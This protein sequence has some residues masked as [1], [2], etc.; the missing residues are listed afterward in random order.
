MVVR[1][2]PLSTALERL[3]SETRI[4]LAY[5]PPLV[6]G[7][8]TSCVAEKVTAEA[9][10]RCVLKG[11]DVD[12]YQLSSG[13]YVLIETP[14]TVPLYGG[15]RGI[16]VDAE[17]RQ[18]LPRSHVML[19]DRESG[20][21]ANEAG[22]FTFSRLRP[23]RYIV[24]ATHVGYEAAATTV[25]V[26]PGGDTQAELALTSD[27][28]LVQ[29]IVIDGL[30]WRLPSA[31]LGR[32]ATSQADLLRN[33]GAGTSDVLAGLNSMLGVRV[34]D[35]TADIHV[36][37]GETGEHQLRLDGAPVFLPLNFA[38]FVGPFSPFA[39]G[40]I[41]VHK[42]GF[43]ASQGSQI[44]GVIDIRHDINF[45]QT[46]RLDVQVDPL[47]ANARLSMRVGREG[48][49]QGA[50]TSAARI[51]LWD[52]YTPPVL[53]SHLG[54]WTAEDPFLYTLFDRSADNPVFE[55]PTTTSGNPRI[56]FR[57]F[58]AAG[59]LR[60]GLLK[61]IYASS[62]FGQ[63]RLGMDLANP[64]PLTP[65]ES[66][67]GADETTNDFR[68]RFSWDTGVAQV[69]YESVLGSKALGTI[70][71]RGSYYRVRHDYSVPDSLEI[72]L[73]GLALHNID[74]NNRIYELAAEGHIDYALNDRN[75]LQLGVEVIKTGSH[76]SVLGTQ[77]YAIVDSSQAWRTSVYLEDELILGAHFTMEPGVRTTFLPSHRRLYTEPRFALRYDQNRGF[78]GPFSAR[79]STGIYRQYSSQFDVSSRSPR[80]LL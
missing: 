44:S 6:K 17:T 27:P 78:L 25:D 73:P 11:T 68:D 37:G 28:I 23:G 15:L 59:R 12:F 26:P 50:F 62:Y 40:D 31:D 22:M 63:S 18:P 80:A 57:D 61:S 1:G 72:D 55:Y 53:N 24:I 46:R 54:Q 42:A 69:R 9:L 65:T 33:P 39:V 70:G 8:R 79:F 3:V 36:Q 5:D 4:D 74:D 71:V 16:V 7:K 49:I 43:A 45:S 58:H 29:P 10:L 19:A 52:V 60:M 64:T 13:L 20:T 21:T 41:T 77:R 35:A 56:G 66:I 47:S 34:S 75:N 76:F 14:E 67:A 30:E 51:S 48:G 38:T 32:T 2:V